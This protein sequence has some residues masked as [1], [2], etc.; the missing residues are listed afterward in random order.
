NG[1]S[2]LRRAGFN[3]WR[4][5]SPREAM[6]AG[7]GVVADDP[8]TAAALAQQVEGGGGERENGPRVTGGCAP[9]AV[10]FARQAGTRPTRI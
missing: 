10:P 1:D 8:A 7:Q 6:V 9:P 4:E 3:R 2:A 5:L